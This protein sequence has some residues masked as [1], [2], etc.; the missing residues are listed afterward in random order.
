M[1]TFISF[2]QF[3]VFQFSHSDLPPKSPLLGCR[4]FLKKIP[5][6]LASLWICVFQLQLTL[7]HASVIPSFILFSSCIS[8]PSSL[9]WAGNLISCSTRKSKSYEAQYLLPYH[10][11]TTYN[12]SHPQNSEHEAGLGHFQLLR[13]WVFSNLVLRKLFIN[14]MVC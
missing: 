14:T 4:A 9:L 6:R 3:R 8:H 2:F 7:Q 10:W 11:T 5:N 13:M 1:A 12:M